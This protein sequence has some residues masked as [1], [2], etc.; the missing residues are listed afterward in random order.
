MNVD[1]GSVA[2]VLQQYAE[3]GYAPALLFDDNGWWAVS[4]NGQGTFPEENHT[5]MEL[6]FFVEAKCWKSSIVEAV[7]YFCAENPLEDEV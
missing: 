1:A 6:C 4:V 2:C 7:A 5:D 3:A